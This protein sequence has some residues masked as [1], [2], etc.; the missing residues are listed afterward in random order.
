MYHYLFTNDLRIS[1]LNESLKK[2]AHCFLTDTIPAATVDKSA[3]NYMNT[4]GFYFNLTRESNCSKEIQQGNVRG[5]VLNFIKKFQFPNYRTKG[6]YEENISDGIQ[7]AP[8]RMIVK[9]LYLMNMLCDKKKAYLTID[10]IKYFIFYNDNVAKTKNPN[11][12]DLINSILQYRDSGKMPAGVSINEDEHVWSYET[13]QLHD[14][15]K[16]FSWSECVIEDGDKVYIDEEALSDD[17]KADIYEIVNYNEFWEGNDLKSYQKYMDMQSENDNG[18]KWQYLFELNNKAFAFECINILQKS[19]LLSEV[20]LCKLTDKKLASQ[21]FKNS[22]PILVEIELD[23]GKEGYENQFKDIKGYS[24]YYTERIDINGKRFAITNNWYYGGEKDADTRTPFVNWIVDEITRKERCKVMNILDIVVSAPQIPKPHNYLLFGAPGTGKSHKIEEMKNKFFK[25]D[26]YERVT[27]YPN[28]SYQNFVGT[29]KPC[30][31]N[32]NISYEYIPGPFMRTLLYAYRHPEKNVLL[33]IEELN[34]AN[35]A[36]VFGDMFQLLDRKEGKSEYFLNTSE[37]LKRFLAKELVPEF[38]NMEDKKDEV[39]ENFNKV[40]IPSN[41]YI[42]ATMNSADQGVF[43]LDTAFKRRWDFEYIGIDDAKKE[44]E[45]YSIPV[46][47]DSSRKYVNWNE[48]RSAINDILIRECNVNEDKLLG[49][50]F[51]SKNV[52]ENARNNIETEN[53]FIKLFESKV[54]MYLF[55]DVLKMRPQNIFKGHAAQN[56]KMIFSEI[57]NAFEKNGVEIFGVDIEIKDI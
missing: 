10:E 17:N 49:P 50:F 43:P 38:E 11:L 45:R 25:E 21:L 56:G 33:I 44:V 16:I 29:Y 39:L 8:M 57:C 13:R 19:K 54:I 36:A 26:E 14:M 53:Q 3:N 37:D 4:L 24:R 48:L 2:A 6:A 31:E 55:E 42:W 1:N 28:Y 20:N 34:R 23:E 46:G 22:F 27:F 40:Y 7:L 12:L 15:I 51:L 9:L 18:E 41:M 35:A 32:S 47:M 52:L 5:V 30:M